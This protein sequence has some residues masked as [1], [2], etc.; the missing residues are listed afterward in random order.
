MLNALQAMDRGGRLK[1]FTA[2]RDRPSGTRKAP[3]A[4]IA[5]QDTGAGMTEEIMNKV[6]EPFFSTKEEGIGL[7]LPIAQRIV[8]EHGGEI[9]V[10]SSPGEGTTF[11]IALPLK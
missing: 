5:F 9:R 2:L 3:S 1:I 8:D 4:E 10:E 11:Y 6:F 7:G